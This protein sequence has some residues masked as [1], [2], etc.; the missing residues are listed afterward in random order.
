M[1]SIH[2]LGALTACL[3]LAAPPVAGAADQ[4]SEV[5]TAHFT[6]VSNASDGNARALVWQPRISTT[7]SR[8]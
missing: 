6:V 7:G 8:R 4:W 5:K 2:G 3:W 1:T